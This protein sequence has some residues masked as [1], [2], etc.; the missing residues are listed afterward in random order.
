MTENPS[1]VAILAARFAELAAALRPGVDTEL[2]RGWFYLLR[3][4]Y[5][6]PHRRYHTLQHLGECLT[7]LESV[8]GLA[9]HPGEVEAA[10]WFHDAICDVGRSDNEERSAGWARI[11]ANQAGVPRDVAERIHALVMVTQHT[12]VPAGADEQLLVDIDLAILGADPQR[13]AEYERQICDEYAHVP[14]EQFRQRRRAILGSFLDRQRVYSTAHFHD[15]LEA[16]ARVN[17]RAAMD[18]C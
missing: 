14:G 9:V 5:R 16:A 17:L 7:L 8:Q 15:R 13:F 1:T 3:G 11:A 2:V 6:Q 4:L 12:G 10:L 18:A